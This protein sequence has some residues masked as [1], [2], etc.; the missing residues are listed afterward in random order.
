MGLRHVRQYSQHSPSGMKG[1]PTQSSGRGS[2]RASEQSGGH[3]GQH[4]PSGM[5]DPAPLGQ[6]ISLAQ[7]T[8]LQSCSQM[9]CGQGSRMHKISIGTHFVP[10]GQ[11]FLASQVTGTQT[12]VNLSKTSNS[13]HSVGGGHLG[14]HSPSGMKGSAPLGHSMNW[15]HFT[16]RQ[17]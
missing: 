14:Q 4:S 2:Q 5:K 1:S 13:G 9:N 3:R 7:S 11:G 10:N 8:R 12:P 15:A 17:S 16:S 6:S